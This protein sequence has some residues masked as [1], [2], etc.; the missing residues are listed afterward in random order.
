MKKILNKFHQEGTITIIR[1]ALEIERVGQYPCPSLL[2]LAK[3]D[4]KQFQSLNI[5]LSDKIEFNRCE[6]RF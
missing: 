5:V 4:R 1:I 3:D 2:S 6:D